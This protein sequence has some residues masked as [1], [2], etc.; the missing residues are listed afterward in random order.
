MQA[1]LEDDKAEDIVV[2]DLKGKSDIADSM[3]IATGRSSRQVVAMAQHVIE[4]LK[5]YGLVSVPTE[6]I[7]HGDWV[8]IDAGDA[9]VH[10]FRPEVRAF[11]NLEKMWDMPLPD[12]D[13]PA[14]AISPG[15]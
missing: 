12:S 14:D 4:R 10:L 2:I 5:A 13:R 15:G 3:L 9:I 1:S 6:G 11:Y 7:Q 8:L